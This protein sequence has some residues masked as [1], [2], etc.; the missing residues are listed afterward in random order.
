MCLTK[1]KANKTRYKIGRL[2][3]D[4]STQGMGWGH[5]LGHA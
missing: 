4:S 3:G 1:R 5:T 2:A